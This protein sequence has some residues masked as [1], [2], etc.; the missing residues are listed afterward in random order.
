MRIDEASFVV[1]DTETTGLSAHQNRII[2]LAMLRV[3]RGTITDRFETLI[4]PDQY[5]SPFI[6]QYTGITNAMVYGKP[7]FAEA[8]PA[9]RDFIGGRQ[10]SV[11]VGH[12]VSFDHG[13]L[14]NSF[15]RSGSQFEVSMEVGVPHLLCTC[16]LARRMLPQL[17]RKSLKHV[18]DYFGIRN[19]R[20]HRAMGDAEATAKVLIEF[21]KLAP[22]YELELLE[23]LLRFQSSRVGAPKKPTKKTAALREQVRGF[24]ER[25]GVY[26]MRDKSGH[27]LYVGKA[28][29]LR[30]RVSSYF[31]ASNTQ[32]TKLA[33]LM[34]S[35]KQI[36][37]EETGSELS[38]LLLESKR[39]K[40][41]HPRFNSMERRYKSQ[42][43]L[44]LDLQNDFPRLAAVREPG[45][46]GS[47]YYGPFRSYDSVVAL[48]DVLNRSFKLREC[49]DDF[50]PS[51]KVKPC[52]YYE[53]KRCNAPCALFETKEHYHEEVERLRRF[54]AAGEQGVLALVQQMMFES[55]ERLDFEEAQF[56]KIRLFELQR[57]LGRGERPLASLNTND[58]VILN[59]T[60]LGPCEVL[61]VRYG[62]LVKQV[63]LSDEPANIEEWFYRQLRMY[64]GPVA[65]VPPACGKPEIDEMRILSHWAEQRRKKGSTIVYIGA[66]WEDSVARLVRELRPLVGQQHAAI[67]AGPAPKTKATS[68][69]NRARLEPE[70]LVTAETNI[71]AP[72]AP[73][74]PKKL[75]AK[76]MNSR[77]EPAGE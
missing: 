29:S 61:F 56:L 1:L 71:A 27:V 5:I 13:F 15:E 73:A 60:T 19:S 67:A 32:G 72:K 36:T 45:D 59:R 66:N 24:P 62:R 51:I 48:V 63:V 50:R 69:K 14:F 58:F 37:Y 70:V 57:V 65:A 54:L 64:Y 43:F 46:D 16:K 44:R 42:T 2:E 21:L 22:E 23:D 11:I 31:I 77:T 8:V 49:G 75:V 20:Q 3:E 52:F 33:Q 30:G 26:T 34:R 68:S 25:P 74:K 76:R 18:Q 47:E 7:S 40:E 28:K 39:I 55:A 53:I 38:A 4:N 6:A 35:A 17:R 12:N 9:I 41:L 10:H